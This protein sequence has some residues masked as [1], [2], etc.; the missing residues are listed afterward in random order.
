MLRK[1]NFNMRI[2][3][4]LL[5]ILTSMIFGTFNVLA[6]EDYDLVKIGTATTFLNPK[7]IN[8]TTNVRLSARAIDWCVLEKGDVFSFNEIV[9]RRTAE[10]GYKKAYV[11]Y[12]QEKKLDLGGG[13]C[14][15]ST[16]MNVAAKDAGLEIIESWPHSM[17]VSYA[18]M[19]DEAAVFYGKKDFKFKNTT[20][21]TIRT[22]T[23]LNEKEGYLRAVIWK[24]VPKVKVE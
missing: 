16:T 24:M 1:V 4:I 17:R 11:F 3:A 7:E 21:Y 14:Q 8:R 20:E 13:I 5:A 9:G 15:T 19:E 12:G 6:E 22:E 23:Y 2:L 10:K 18:K